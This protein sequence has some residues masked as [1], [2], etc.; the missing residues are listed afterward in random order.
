MLLFGL[1]GNVA[2]AQDK[3]VFGFKP[4]TVEYRYN[5]TTLVLIDSLVG[6]F[7]HEIFRREIGQSDTTLVGRIVV[8]DTTMIVPDI[9]PGIWAIG[10]RAYSSTARSGI[11]HWSTDQDPKWT[12]NPEEFWLRV[13]K[14]GEFI[15]FLL[16][17]KGN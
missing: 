8:G 1:M 11:I 12:Y 6:F 3:L 9:P 16:E 2:Y 17:R 5:P 4:V 10:Y 15:Y 13:L 14:K 7:P